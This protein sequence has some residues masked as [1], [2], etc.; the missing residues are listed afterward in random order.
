MGD[1]RSAGFLLAA[2]RRP[3]R[4]AFRPGQRARH[5]LAAPLGADRSGNREPLHAVQSSSRRT[6]ALRSHQLDAVGRGRARL[7]IRLLARR[8]E[9]ADAVGSPVRRFRQRRAGGVRPVHLLG[10]A[11]VAAHVRSRLLLPHGY[12]GQGPEHSS[13][14]LERFLQMCAEDNMQ[15]A[16]C[17]TPA[18]YFH[19]LRRQLKRDFRKP[20]ILMTPKSLLRHKRAVSRLDEMGRRRRSTGCCGTTRRRRR[21]RRSSSSPTTR[22]AA[23]SSAPARSITT[24]TTSAKSAASTTSTCCASSSS[25]RSRPRR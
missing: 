7:R 5:L 20:L 21:T 12:E 24:S 10:R 2:A 6:G 19:I 18:N 22:S 17:T 9:R 8:A 4:P 11:Q 16:N 1:R 15:V 13:A 25:I 3:S 23:S 14:R